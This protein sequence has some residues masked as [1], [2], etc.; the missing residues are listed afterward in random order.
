MV[1]YMKLMKK[2]LSCA[3]AL[4][5][6][7]CLLPAASAEGDGDALFKDKTWDELMESFLT[8]R[9]IDTDRVAAGYLNTVTGEEHY[10]NADEYMVAGSMYKVPLNM[11]YAELVQKG[12]MDWDTEVYGIRY[13]W[14]LEDSIVNSNND[15]AEILWRNLGSG[16][17][18]AYR[19]LIAPY[20]GED[21]DAVDSKYY[22]NNFFTPRQMISCL[23]LLYT[24]QDR[25]PKIIETMQRAEPNNYFKLDEQ[26]FDIAHKYGFLQEEYHLYLNDCGLAFT[27]E[28]IALVMFTDNVSDAYQVLTDYCTLM[29]DYAQYH[30]AAALAAA[31]PAPSPTPAPTAV[32][33]PAVTPVPAAEPDSGG[34]L[35]GLSFASI[36]VMALIIVAMLAFLALAI[37]CRRRGGV[38]L[39]WAVAAIVLAGGAL[40]L[41]VVGVSAGTIIAKPEGDPRETVTVFMDAL[42]GGDYETAYAQLDGYTSLGLEKEPEDEVGRM[43]YRAL[44]ESLSYE[45]VGDCVIDR[46]DA[47]QEIQLS[48]LDLTAIQPDVRAATE[49]ELEDIVQSRTRGEVYDDDNNYLP[50]VTQEAYSKAVEKVLAKAEDYYTTVGIR[51][52]IKYTGGRW[53]AVANQTL[54]TAV[55]GGAY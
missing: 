16:S 48:Y 3:A 19:R 8:E 4:C 43:M 32:P 36:A 33:T 13:D 6:L 2:I 55:S 38:S 54:L 39:P 21:P 25:F 22:E 37:R 11:Y 15:Y 34:T 40:L 7:L 51:L 46:L 50:A 52:E 30:T 14:L 5:L 35:S 29:C 23:K 26:R 27:D 9:G 17:Y 45:L 49:A 44:R 42:T 24:E 41:S 18:S 12:E 1:I 20:M 53:L 47:A 10:L 31:T 28:P